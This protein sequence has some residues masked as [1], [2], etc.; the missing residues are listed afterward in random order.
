MMEILLAYNIAITII[1]AQL[2]VHYKADTAHTQLHIGIHVPQGL[3]LTGPTF[4]LYNFLS[5]NK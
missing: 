3:P 5:C 1:H 2:K 4:Q